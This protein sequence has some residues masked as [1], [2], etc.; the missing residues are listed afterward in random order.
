MT[1]Y[2]VNSTVLSCGSRWAPVKWKCGPVLSWF[3]HVLSPAPAEHQKRHPGPAQWKWENKPFYTHTKHNCTLPITQLPR[4]CFVNA[5]LTLNL[6]CNVQ[7]IMGDY[8][9]GQTRHNVLEFLRAL[10]HCGCGRFHLKVST[11][12]R[13]EMFHQAIR[14]IKVTIQNDLQELS[15]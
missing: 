5:Q 1:Q 14:V 2:S 13:T 12:I 9:W 4:S 6:L 8:L 3:W 15:I 10:V 11:H 7:R